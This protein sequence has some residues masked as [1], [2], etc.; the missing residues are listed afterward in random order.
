[1]GSREFAQ[2]CFFFFWVSNE[3]G[4]GLEVSFFENLGLG[5]VR[6]WCGFWKC[7]DSSGIWEW[8]WRR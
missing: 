2:V 6:V 3:G 8:N 5:I 4:L 7:G 1:M